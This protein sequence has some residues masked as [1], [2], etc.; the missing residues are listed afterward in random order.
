MIE[1]YVLIMTITCK[2]RAIHIAYVSQIY[3]TLS[4]SSPCN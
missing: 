1:C 2:L 3:N 4:Y